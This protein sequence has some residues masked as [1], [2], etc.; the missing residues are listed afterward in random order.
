MR[1]EAQRAIAAD[2]VFG[3]VHSDSILAHQ[4][5]AAALSDLIGRRLGGNIA[6][7]AHFARL[8]NDAFRGEPDLGEAAS[9]DL[10]AIV[11]R[12]PAAYTRRALIYAIAK[13][14]QAL[15]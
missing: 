15:C 7:H 5:F 2:P 6:T 8:A 10:R 14:G 12:D 1:H 4:D 11:V 13:H 9:R 3:A